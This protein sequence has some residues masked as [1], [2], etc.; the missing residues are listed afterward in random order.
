[1][2]KYFLL[3]AIFILTSSAYTASFTG[4]NY[5]AAIDE[6]GNLASLTSGGFEFVRSAE[7]VKGKVTVSGSEVTVT[8]DGGKVVY[9]FGKDKIDVRVQGGK[10]VFVPLASVIR[11]PDMRY[12]PMPVPVHNFRRA[13]FLGG[14]SLIVCDG[15]TFSAEGDTPYATA[16]GVCSITIRPMTE[17]ERGEYDRYTKTAAELHS[18]LNLYT[19]QNYTVFQRKTKYEGTASFR[20]SVNPDFDA[21]KGRI[22]GTGLK[23]CIDRT[24]DIPFDKVTG[25]FDETVPVPAG[26]W[27]TVTVTAYKGGKIAAQR[28]IAHVG[29]GEVF[30]GAGQSN[31][32][33]S[34]QYQIIQK[35]G[36]VS[37]FDGEMWRLANDPQFGVHEPGNRNGS[38]YP[39][40]G[41]AMYARYKVPIGIASTGHG[42]TIIEQWLP[43]GPGLFDYTVGRMKQFGVG[44]FRA[45]LWHQG[46]TS[47]GLKLT[48]PDTEYRNMRRLINASYEAAGW[49]FPWFVAKVSYQSPEEPIDENMRTVHQRLWDT[50]VALQ[51]PDTDTLTGD[52]RDCDGKGIHLSPKGLRRHG[53]MWAECVSKYLDKIL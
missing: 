36:M 20:G 11:T 51:G 4:E 18:D 19:P 9:T 2:R 43:G 26:G 15:F 16:V 46:E 45:V 25:A 33:N 24:F 23:G 50:G 7:S 29:V 47:V 49:C 32:V 52:M 12:A 40:F 42:A 17:A 14:D 31:S 10:F 44:G 8:T 28:T 13:A 39:A 21:L 5:T 37:S 38:Y 35:S 41:D 22:A 53:E 27:Y 6:G 1:M 3:L 34:A 30:I 48:D